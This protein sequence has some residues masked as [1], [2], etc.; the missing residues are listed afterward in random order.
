MWE[1]ELLGFLVSAEGIRPQAERVT[2]IKVLELPQ[3]FKAI[4]SF[5]GM[6]GYYRQCISGFS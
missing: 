5:L 1:I 4:R 2:A 3:D 6:A